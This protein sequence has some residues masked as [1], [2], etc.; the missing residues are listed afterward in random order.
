MFDHAKHSVAELRNYAL[1]SVRDI[2]VMYPKRNARYT[3]EERRE[4]EVQQFTN[5]LIKHCGYRANPL[6]IPAQWLE[7][8]KA[9]HQVGDPLHAPLHQRGYWHDDLMPERIFVLREHVPPPAD[10]A[11]PQPVEEDF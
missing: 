7:E 1:C 6:K 9:P 8:M 4:I 11:D 10:P 2:E 3:N 5:Y